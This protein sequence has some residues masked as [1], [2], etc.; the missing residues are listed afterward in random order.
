MVTLVWVFP[1]LTLF[2]C[3]SLAKYSAETY[4]LLENFSLKAYSAE[5]YGLASCI[6]RTYGTGST[7]DMYFSSISSVISYLP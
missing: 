1:S 6:N 5:N 2:L 3:L 4:F 7:P